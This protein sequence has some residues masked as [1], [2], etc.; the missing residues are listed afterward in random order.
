MLAIFLFVACAGLVSGL[1]GLH[2]FDLNIHTYTYVF[3]LLGEAPP[4]FFFSLF[5][6]KTINWGN[7]GLKYYLLNYMTCRYLYYPVASK[8]SWTSD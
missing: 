8:P 1:T 7:E 2:C 6:M 5:P 3:K 4:I